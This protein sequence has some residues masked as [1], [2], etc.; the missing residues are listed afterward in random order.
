MTTIKLSD[1]VQLISGGSIMTVAKIGTEGVTCVWLVNGV[2]R[3]EVFASH[4]L[5]RA[6]RATVTVG[7][8]SARP[9]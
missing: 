4:T 2:H 3:K 5:K 7:T 6:N 9:F 8:L 1:T